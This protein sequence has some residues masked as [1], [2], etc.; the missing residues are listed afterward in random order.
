MRKENSAL[1]KSPRFDMA[2]GHP[3]VQRPQEHQKAER[4]VAAGLSDHQTPEAG[5]V[6]RLKPATTGI[7]DLSRNNTGIWGVIRIFGLKSH[8]FQP[9]P[10]AGVSVTDRGLGTEPDHDSTL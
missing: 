6:R 3:G 7:S 1:E 8:S 9:K 4:R 10:K 5:R 2:E